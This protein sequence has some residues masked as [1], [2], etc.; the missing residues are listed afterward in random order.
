MIHRPRV[1]DQERVCVGLRGS[2]WGIGEASCGSFG[3]SSSSSPVPSFPKSGA[4]NNGISA[5]VPAGGVSLF[6]SVT[7]AKYPGGSGTCF[8]WAGGS[9]GWPLS[10][11]CVDGSGDFVTSGSSVTGGSADLPF[12]FGGGGDDSFGALVTSGS[13]PA[14]GFS[15]ALPFPGSI[16]SG[17]GAGSTECSGS[18]LR[19]AFGC[20]GFFKC[21]NSMSDERRSCSSFSS[22][23][24]K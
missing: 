3:V 5:G 11:G 15:G 21:S 6:L 20:L 24:L 19:G 17:R 16:D 9:D 8:F 4:T 12:S 23:F 7:R 14:G 18:S 2:S 10:F 13:S 1:F 22:G